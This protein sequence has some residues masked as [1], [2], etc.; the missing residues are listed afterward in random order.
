MLS[1]NLL[2]L[3]A[4][5]AVNKY[6]QAHAAMYYPTTVGATYHKVFKRD[7]FACLCFK[8]KSSG[9][10]YIYFNGSYDPI[11]FCMGFSSISVVSSDSLTR[12]VNI[13]EHKT[14]VESMA[15]LEDLYSYLSS[16]ILKKG[17]E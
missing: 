7:S 16:V 12:K 8:T 10:Y 2:F 15:D 9:N 6:L 11:S 4:Y 14:H 5:V 17:D 1:H 13:V 3:N